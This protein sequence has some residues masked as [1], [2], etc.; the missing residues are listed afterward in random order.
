MYLI[1]FQEKYI[2]CRVTHSQMNSGHIYLI[3]WFAAKLRN[4]QVSFGF[5]ENLKKSQISD[6][7]FNVNKN[8]RLER[9]F[10]KCSKIF[11]DRW[12]D[13]GFCLTPVEFEGEKPSLQS[14][15]PTFNKQR[16]AKKDKNKY[17]VNFFEKV[18]SKRLVK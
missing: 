12:Q 5:L 15:S 1:F 6:L 11:L 8:L 14:I 7:F 9:Y 3:F 18:A 13:L 17:K 10:R 16:F 2:I 4:C